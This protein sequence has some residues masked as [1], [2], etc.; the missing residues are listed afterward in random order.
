MLTYLT[1]RHSSIRHTHITEEIQKMVSMRKTEITAGIRSTDEQ[2]DE[3]G[4]R[5]EQLSV[6]T[7]TQEDL[8]TTE[9]KVGAKKQA[10]EERKALHASRKL[11]DELL[12]KVQNNCI[13]KAASISVNFGDYNS[14]FQV[15]VS[16]GPISGMSFGVKSP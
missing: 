8:G 14:G 12:M 13:A 6:V 4:T 5:I 2:L 7:N 11:L 10:E 15:G 3:V 16:N 1:C 9:D